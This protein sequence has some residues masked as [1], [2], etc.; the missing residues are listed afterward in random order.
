MDDRTVKKQNVFG[1]RFYGRILFGKEKLGNIKGQS[2]FCHG[3]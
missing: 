3:L 1:K 2:S